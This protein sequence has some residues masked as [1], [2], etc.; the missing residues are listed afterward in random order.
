M[1]RRESKSLPGSEGTPSETKRT[2]VLAYGKMCVLVVEDDEH[3][4]ARIELLL[5]AAQFYVFAVGSAADARPAPSAIYND[6]S[7]HLAVV[8]LE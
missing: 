6:D 5:S 7:P 1:S 4:R 8:R 3:A 2:R